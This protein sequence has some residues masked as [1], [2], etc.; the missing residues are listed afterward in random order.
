[1]TIIAKIQT[2]TQDINATTIA[3]MEK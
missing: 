3:I 1:M 2:I